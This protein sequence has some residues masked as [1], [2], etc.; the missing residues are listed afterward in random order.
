MEK[1]YLTYNEVN[2]LIPRDVSSPVDLDNLLTTIGTRG[3]DVLEDQP[4]L[5]SSALKRQFEEGFEPGEDI[6]LDLPPA[7]LEKT[8]DPVRIYLREMGTVP[9]LTREGEVDI[10]K[11]LERG[12]LRTLKALSRSPIVIRQI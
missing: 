2:N 1:G 5:A 9:L 4:K 6:G 3:I 12:Q 11:H 10:A 7:T 8:N